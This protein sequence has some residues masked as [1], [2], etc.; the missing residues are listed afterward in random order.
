MFH[1]LPNHQPQ[2]LYLV[3][4]VSKVLVG[5]SDTATAPYSNPERLLSELEQMK[6]MEKAA[7]CMKRLGRYHQPLAWG[8][9]ALYEGTKRNMTMYRQRTTM[10]D[11]QRI[12]FIQEML[13][14]TYK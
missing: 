8:C 12:Q 5:D 13:K 10:S 14:G 3:L 9:I 4:K 2:H 6:L 7:D 11:E 1:L